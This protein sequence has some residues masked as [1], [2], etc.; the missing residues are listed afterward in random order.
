MLSS[1]RKEARVFAYCRVSTETERQ[2]IER[3]IEII[4][5]AYPEIREEDIY[6]DVG[7]GNSFNETCRKKWC[8]LINE[9]IKSGD[10]IVFTEVS[11]F[12]RNAEEGLRVYRNLTS[13]N[14]KLVFLRK[15]Q[16]RA[17]NA[18]ILD[19]LSEVERFLSPELEAAQKENELKA[20][21]TAEEMAKA[22]SEG[23][24]AGAPKGKRQKSAKAAKLKPLLYKHNRETI[25]KLAPILDAH[26]ELKLPRQDAKFTDVDFQHR[27]KVSLKTIRK[28]RAEMLDELTTY[29]NT[30]DC[31]EWII[32]LKGTLKRRQTKK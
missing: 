29:I 8:F 5:E 32:D 27:Y 2:N 30:G 17:G 22:A 7:T 14:I 15:D 26:P 23:R 3:Q 6:K 4:K 11:R 13:Q 10:T 12:S 24:K 31:A 21:R 1:L 18:A 25:R 9:V 19:T 20:Q 16:Q 28:Y